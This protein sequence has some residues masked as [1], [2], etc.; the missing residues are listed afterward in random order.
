MQITASAPT[1]YDKIRAIEA[2]LGAHVRYSIDAPLAPHG[3][4]VVDDFLFR[5]RLGWC[6]QVASSLV[7]MAR[8][9]GIPARLATGFVPGTRD[10]L[11]GQFTVR[12]RDAHAWAEIYFPGVGWQPFDP[13]ASV[14]LAGD[15]STNGSWL[16]TARHH[17]VEFGLIAVALVLA[18][19]AA[20]DVLARA[21]RRRA[22]RRSSW[23]ARRLRALGAHR[24]AG[25]DGRVLRRRRRASTPTRWRCT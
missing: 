11:T 10:A 22:R 20:P 21:R 6:E 7:V 8:S 9:V 17:A 25:R 18:V 2:W 23:A 15:T 14:P 24:S 5:S 3:V 1:T 19:V 13:T 12:E 4:D 16:Q